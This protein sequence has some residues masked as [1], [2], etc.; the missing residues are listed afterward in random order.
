MKK[1]ILLGVIIAVVVAGM[2][3]LMSGDSIRLGGG[4]GSP[5]GASPIVLGLI[6]LPFVVAPGIPLQDDS[7]KYQPTHAPVRRHLQR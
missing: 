6:G 2:G 1:N 4:L 5:K 3:I 7:Q